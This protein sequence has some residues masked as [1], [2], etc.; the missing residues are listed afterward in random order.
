[1]CQ[2]QLLQ[3]ISVVEMLL[4]RVK[5]IKKFFLFRKM[6]SL[7]AYHFVGYRQSMFKL[8]TLF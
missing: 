2:K 5:S 3:L 8:L 1:M 7:Y 4:R 6:P